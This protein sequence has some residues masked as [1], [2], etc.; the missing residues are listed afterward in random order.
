MMLP[1]CLTRA[2]PAAKLDETRRCIGCAIQT[3]G[4]TLYKT[5]MCKLYCWQ[6]CGWVVRTF[7][8]RGSDMAGE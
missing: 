2:L 3:I 6:L 5:Q 8:I 7:R 4:R 1:S